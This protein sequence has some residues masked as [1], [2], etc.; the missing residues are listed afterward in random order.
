MD[1]WMD[2]SLSLSLSL[3]PPPFPPSHAHTHAC[4]QTTNVHKIQ[5]NYFKNKTSSKENE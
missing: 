1:G 4:R 5:I 2:L 3:P